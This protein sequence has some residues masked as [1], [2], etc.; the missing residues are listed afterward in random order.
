MIRY[1]L[2]KRIGEYGTIEN[3]HVVVQSWRNVEE[4]IEY[5]RDNL[6]VG[7]YR[8]TTFGYDF[9]DFT[10]YMPFDLDCIKRL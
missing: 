1:H 10:E 7:E 6:I 5:L 8:D 2:F 4:P 9:P 3:W